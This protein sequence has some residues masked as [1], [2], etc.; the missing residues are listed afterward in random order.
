MK[1]SITTIVFL[2]FSFSS[3]LGQNSPVKRHI[4]ERLD[5]L[6][7]SVFYLD[8]AA[9]SLDEWHPTDSFSIDDIRAAEETWTKFKLLCEKD[10]YKKALDYYLGE[11]ADAPKKNSGDIIVFLK[12]STNQYI[13]ASDVLRPLLFEYRGRDV[14]YG[15][16]IQLFEFLKAMGDYMIAVNAEGNGYVPEIYPQ[17][18]C[19]LGYCLAAVGRAEEALDLLEDFALGVSSIVD[20]PLKV[21]Y[22]I[23]LYMANIARITG[24]TQ[25]AIETWE[26]FK[27]YHLAHGDEFDPDELDACLEVADEMI[28]E[29]K[30][31]L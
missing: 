17:V 10:E 30:E 8:S 9:R 13:F 20:S 16:L 5:G 2:L 29:I 11:G 6:K 14:A 7:E 24:E 25:E 3:C 18:V 23:T 26:D 22:S 12:H 27:S 28:A 31:G 4:P 15:E 19:D 21:N 1:K